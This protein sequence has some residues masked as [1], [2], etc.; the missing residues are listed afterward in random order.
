VLLMVRGLYIGGC[1]RDLTKIAIA[2]DRSR[3]DPHVA[4]FRADGPRHN[5]LRAAGVPVLPLPVRSFA[6]PSV[7]RAAIELARYLREHR[8]PLIHAFDVPT[9][10][11]AAIASAVIHIPAVI[12]AQLSFRDL[13]TPTTRWLLSI[14]DRFADRIVV[15]SKAVKLSLCDHE[16]IRAD[17]IALIYNGVDATVF[18]P[19]SRHRPPNLEKASLVIGTICAFRQEKRV[20]LLIRAFAKVKDKCPGMKL[21]IVGRGEMRPDIEKLIAETGIGEDCLLCPETPAVAEWMRAMDIFVLCSESESFPNA[22]LEAMAC[23]CCVIGSRVGGVP[24]LITDRV[25]GLLFEPRNVDALAGALT[26]VIGNADLRTRFGQHAATTAREE[27]SVE[28]AA[29][30]TEALYESA[31]ALAAPAKTV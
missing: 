23:G 14:S 20:D 30:R 1:E 18:H 5:D 17:R 25:N 13:Y 6:S 26:E 10:V 3:F 2:L 4:C 19:G 7:V 29:R 24:E 8:I 12:T 16:G 15:N 27:F 28:I 11:F 31:L 22:L 21:I 9:S